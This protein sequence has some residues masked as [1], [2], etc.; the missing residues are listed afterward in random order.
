M[1]ELEGLP[2]ETEEIFKKHYL[3]KRLPESE[4][5][6]KI[7]SEASDKFQKALEIYDS[8]KDELKYRTSDEEGVRDK[9]IKRILEE[10]LDFST[11]KEKTDKA[12]NQ[13]DWGLFKDEED[14]KNAVKSLNDDKEDFYQTA[15]GVLEAKAWN[16][17]LGED[18][19]SN[20][21]PA[22][23]L[24]RKYLAVVKPDWGILTNGN[25][26]RLYHKDKSARLKSYFAID[27]EDILDNENEEGFKLFYFLFRKESL[28]R[29]GEKPTLDR[30]SSESNRFARELGENLEDNVYKALEWLAKGFKDVKANELAE[31]DKKEIHDESL[32]LLYRLLFLFYTHDKEIIEDPA[33]NGEEFYSFPS[34]VDEILDDIDSN[35]VSEYGVSYWNRL[36]EIFKMIDK[37]SEEQGIDEDDLYIPAY[38]GKLFND[39]HH[40]F[41]KNNTLR[42][43]YL[44][45]VI[46]FL[47]RMDTDERVD[48]STFSIRHLG[49]IYEG[50]LEY[51]LEI[52]SEKKIAINEDGSEKWKPIDDAS[53]DEEN[54]EE[55]K[56]VEEGEPYLVTDKGERKATGSYYTPDYVVKYIVEK[57][58]KPVIEEKIEQGETDE[59]IRENLYSTK[60]LDPAMGS[61][62]FLVDAVDLIASEIVN[63]TEEPLDKVRRKVS[64]K[65][66]Y[67]V[68][69]NELATELAKVSVWLNV[70]SQDK[71]LSFLDHHLKQG[72][73]LIGSDIFDLDSHPNVEED[74][75]KGQVSLEE[76]FS[77]DN[78]VD[79]DENIQQ[80]IDMYRNIVDISE[81]K[82]KDIEEQEKI[83]QKFRDHKFRKRFNTLADVYTSYFF[84]NKYSEENYQNLLEAFNPSSG[85]WEEYRNK[86][87]VEKSKQLSEDFSFFHWKLEFPSVFFDLKTGKEKG[88][89]G[90]DVVIGNPPYM[91]ME[92]IPE[93]ARRFC[94]GKEVDVSSPYK[95][96]H[97]KTNIYA[98]F[99]EKAINLTQKAGYFG[100]ITPY[101]WMGNTSFEPLRK[102]FL[103][104]TDLEEL[105][106][107]PLGVFDDAD[108]DSSILIAEKSDGN[109]QFIGRDLSDKDVSLLPEL[110]YEVE[111]QEYDQNNFKNFPDST[112]TLDIS[113]Q[114]Q[115]ILTKLEKNSVKL[116]EIAKIDR[117]CDPADTDRFT[118]DNDDG[119][120]PQKLIRGEDFEQYHYNWGGDYLFYDPDKMKELNNYARPGDPER[121]E[122]D[123][124]IIIYRFLRN[125]QFVACLDDSQ[126]YTLGSTYVIRKDEE[127]LDLKTLLGYINSYVSSYYTSKF[128]S[129]NRITSTQL[130]RTP[131]GDLKQDS[132]KEKVEQIQSLKREKHEKAEKLISWLRYSFGVDEEVLDTIKDE[133]PLEDFEAFYNLLKD[134]KESIEEDVE[135]YE[136]YEKIESSWKEFDDKFDELDKEISQNRS[137][138][139]EAVFENSNLDPEEKKRVKSELKLDNK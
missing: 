21:N 81:N 68:D 71:P 116:G 6:K 63:Y 122:A 104:S 38:N 75:D 138:I 49:G 45:K 52:A 94:Y 105:S 66:I 111:G 4:E 80:L 83:Y 120:N 33:D 24:V 19:E 131:I 56:V 76:K 109:G 79:I 58:L 135:S 113:P 34:L 50:L 128:F 35:N 106:L 46:D 39:D 62:H 54:V 89:P 117:G 97:R 95:T 53:T 12:N 72:N 73:S 107:L 37:G 137:E 98:L 11:E 67:G 8:Q 41:L 60:I 126:Y 121:F 44:A 3:Q 74:S 93:S 42:D 123:Q 27:L 28:V 25:E 59:E 127:E 57:S 40:E 139:E 48:Y 102:M 64:R 103:D 26:W 9:F 130:K 30:V 124:K 78:G 100:Y 91:V 18:R 115:N 7:N 118:S 125:N 82:K 119:E 20:D 15:I 86:E 133:M 134:N 85:K 31:E 23:Q 70:I 110:L 108:I 51:N 32:I 96:A 129:G 77:N 92:N 36:I 99:Y 13:P 1:V 61:G 90:F 87:W 16:K 55:D 136:V 14:R 65:C 132:I 47:E 114:D 101:S 29:T 43:Q 112:F 22:F 84:G 2:A 69:K 88:N 5:W 17:N 10:V